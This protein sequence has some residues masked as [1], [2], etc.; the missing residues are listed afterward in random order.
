[1]NATCFSLEITG[2]IYVYIVKTFISPR[3]TLVVLVVLLFLSFHYIGYFDSGLDRHEWNLQLNWRAEAS[4]HGPVI[5]VTACIS[6]SIEEETLCPLKYLVC[7]VHRSVTNYL[8]LHKTAKTCMFV[9]LIACGKP[10]W[11]STTL[12]VACFFDNATKHASKDHMK[13][14]RRQ[15]S[16]DCHSESPDPNF[17]L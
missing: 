7:F 5:L 13:T 4:N 2:I 3:T 15:R 1:M 8:I 10:N 12:I 14:K 11:F 16:L 6:L 9:P 17:S